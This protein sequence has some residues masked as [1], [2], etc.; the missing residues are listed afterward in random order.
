MIRNWCLALALTA[1]LGIANVWRA[2]AADN[3]PPPGTEITLANWQQ[4]KAFMPLGMQYLFAGKYFWKLPP[5]VKIVV[6]PTTHY[7]LPQV[8]LDN[9]R[10]YADSVKIINLSDGGHAISGYV[11]G[12]PFPNPADPMK[13][14]KIL[15][16]SWY[17]YIPYL[18][19]GNE[20]HEI[21]ENSQGQ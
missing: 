20:D 18:F 7:E 15:V 14:Y 4:Y 16:N 12:Q 2:S 19:C 21:L 3:P 11:A 5:D 8:Y 17:R 13:G 10:K 9:N 1:A 6:S